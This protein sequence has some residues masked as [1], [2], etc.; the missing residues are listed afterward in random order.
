MPPIGDLRGRT[1]GFINNGHH[2]GTPVLEAMREILLSRYG[3]ANVLFRTKP[4]ISLPAS[5]EMGVVDIA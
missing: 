3:V 2:N 4:R 5:E 1:V